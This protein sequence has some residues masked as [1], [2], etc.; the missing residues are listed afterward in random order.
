MHFLN[1]SQENF[2]NGQCLLIENLIT[3]YRGLIAR[4][5][6]MSPFIYPFIL[7][8]CS[9]VWK[10]CR[11][12]C[13]DFGSYHNI[14]RASCEQDWFIWSAG[15]LKEWPTQF[16]SPWCKFR[17]NAADKRSS[18]T[19]VPCMHSSGRLKLQFAAGYQRAGSRYCTRTPFTNSVRWCLFCWISLRNDDPEVAMKISSVQWIFPVPLNM[20]FK[21][22]N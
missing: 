21:V 9:S 16:P 13:G 8:C 10:N 1:T 3:L 5:E 20:Y 2:A 12:Q 14:Y 11:N 6:L 4:A 7:G 19:P 17:I 15:S 18:T 22:R